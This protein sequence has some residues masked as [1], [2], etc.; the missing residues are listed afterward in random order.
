[1]VSAA[2]PL[3][4]PHEHQIELQTAD[5]PSLKWM[6]V[7]LAEVTEMECRVDANCIVR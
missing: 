5:A 3:P 4:D 1:M 7:S 2:L 6:S